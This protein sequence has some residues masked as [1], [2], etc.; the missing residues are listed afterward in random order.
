M[1]ERDFDNIFRRKIEQLPADAPDQQIWQNIDNQLNT[2]NGSNKNWLKVTLAALLLAS[3]L[4]N[5][6]FW[7]KL[8][9]QNTAIT[10]NK[11][12]QNDTIY[13]RTVVYRY[14]TISTTVHVEEKITTKTYSDVENKSIFSSKKQMPNEVVIVKNENGILPKNQI[15]K[16]SVLENKNNVLA[17]KNTIKN[18]TQNIENKLQITEN[19]NTQ[20]IDKEVIVN[21]SEDNKTEVVAGN[22]TEKVIEIA[23]NTVE[24]TVEN[25]TKKELKKEEKVAT[26]PSL[27]ESEAAKNASMPSKIKPVR[28][29][30]FSRWSVGI[31]SLN[32]I[33]TEQKGRGKYSGIGLSVATNFKP[34]WRLTANTDLE[35]IDFFNKEHKDDFR[36]GQQPNVNPI[37]TL[38]G[39]RTKEQPYGQF[40]IGL[41]RTFSY[42]K[43]EAFVG[44]STGVNVVLPYNIQHD[45]KRKNGNN[46]P[47]MYD[48]KVTEGYATFGGLQF[49]AGASYPIYKHFNFMLIAQYQYNTPNEKL[50]WQNQFGFKTGIKYNF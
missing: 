37:D 46:P 23:Q 50:N 38:A 11:V 6:F 49:N 10:K 19:N 12:T 47:I 29:P 24:N 34:N 41:E 1:T 3:L 7:K 26:N 39:W 17:K 22:T 31:F 13:N 4:S 32:G 44:V 14:D 36:N 42:K 20:N 30:I 45:T 40:S 28:E 5:F 33:L 15:E 43:V 16:S 2:S 27:I 9:E 8:D 25:T 21:K 48:E 18:E 35:N